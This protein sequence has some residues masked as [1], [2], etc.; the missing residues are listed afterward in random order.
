MAQF[1]DGSPLASQWP[2]PALRFFD[3]EVEAWPSDAGTYFYHSHVGIQA[4]TA[5]GSLIVED[6]GA[7]P[8]AYDD[9]RTFL[10]GDY[11]NKT[12]ESLEKGLAGFPFV[13]GG[14][15][16]AVLLNGKGIGIGHTVGDTDLSCELPTID[17][18]AGKTYRFRFIGSTSLSHSVVAFEYHPN[19]TV[20]SV[21]GGEYTQPATTERIQLG[22]GQR[23]DI[24]FKA[25]TAE[26]LAAEGKS[27]YFIQFETRD[28]PALYRGYG[29]LRYN[30]SA[31]RPAP[32]AEPLVTISNTT[33]DWLE[34]TLTPL[35]PHADFPTLAEVTRRVV[36]DAVQLIDPN[37]QQWVWRLNNLSWT[38]ATART[39]LMV[40]IY[41]R[42]QAAVPDFDAA[43]AN[44]GW[45]PATKAFPARL[46][47]VLEIVFQNT[48]SL[49]NGGGGV[50]VHPFH[51]H[52]EHYFDVGGGDGSY[53]A[54]ANEASIVAAGY[55]PVK[56]D[57]TMLYRYVTNAGAGV[58]AGWRAWRIRVDDPGVWM[59][60]C[61]TLQHMVMGKP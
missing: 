4:L 53:D 48:G 14:E 18:E 58:P 47:E 12:D 7:P 25:K 23:F 40:D 51:A 11:F 28:R 34:N 27:D 44:D 19:L 37:T 24:L 29:L 17:V 30:T 1:S 26:E 42:G 16:N 33:Y 8:Y 5:S 38:E 41:E 13:F 9:E 6:C 61:H 15:T 57:T 46:G 32:P 45:D 20:I 49:A 31:P 54:E 60:H 50:D 52:G 3:Y 21:D 55:E 2:I 22:S 39:P 43:V 59:I 36:I 10:F 35:I 56:R